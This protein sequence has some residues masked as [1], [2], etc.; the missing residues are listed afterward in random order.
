MHMAALR[1]ES[2]T[3]PVE[4]APLFGLVGPLPQ[5]DKLTEPF[6]QACRDHRLVLQRCDDCRGYQH[7]P[8][9]ICHR[10]LS[11]RLAWDPV[12]ETGTIYTAVNV[13]HKVYPDTEDALPY[14][15]VLVELDGIGMRV[16][17]NV[18]GAKFEDVRIGSRV[19]VVWDQVGEDDVLPRW[20]LL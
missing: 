19:R 5:A 15:V 7:P 9:I 2:M 18:V 1:R 20:T 4:A 8:E 10:C 13:T 3:Q 16:Y 17:G 12:P 11:E 14:N 6:W